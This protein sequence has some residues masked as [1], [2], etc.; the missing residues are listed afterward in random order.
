MAYYIFLKSLRSLEEF[1]KNPHAKI[2]PKSLSTNFQSLGKFKNPIFIR[3]RIFPSLS[4]QSALRLAGPPGLLAQPATG[5]FPF[6]PTGR[7]RARPILACAAIAYWPKYVSFSRLHSLA[8]TP[9]PYVTVKWVPHV[10][11]ISHLAPADPG[12]AA[13]SLSHPAPPRLC[14]KMPS[15]GVNSPP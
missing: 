12:H 8:T 6:S 5:P 10:S 4:A 7:A 13:A 11:S 15:Q 1:R 3:K 14:L 2:P 9:S